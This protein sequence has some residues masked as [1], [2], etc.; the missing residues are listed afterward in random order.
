MSLRSE[1]AVAATAAI[2]QAVNGFLQLDPNSARSLGRFEGKVIAMVLEGSGVTLYC[3]P[4]QNGMHIMTQYTGP[5][6]TTIA[7]RPAAMLRLAVGDSRQVLFSGEVT[8]RGDVELGQ[9]FKRMLDKLHIDWEEHLSRLTNDLIAHK[10]GFVAREAASWLQNAG[11]RLSRDGAEY[12]QQE[13]FA[14]PTHEEVEAY[15]QGVETLRDDV[16]RLAA[17]IQQLNS[18]LKT[19]R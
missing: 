7:G 16:A 6:D 1:L 15:Y 13:V 18:K 17:R 10:L 12:L 11:Q 3:L 8:I 19:E 14:T 5:V 9:R 2:E 4:G